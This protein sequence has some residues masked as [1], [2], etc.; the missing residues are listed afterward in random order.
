M[1]K[2]FEKVN[3]GNLASRNRSVRSS[4]FSGRA[5]EDGRFSD[6]LID[7]LEQLAKGEV[8]LIITGLSSVLPNGKA[9]PE[10]L[11]GHDDAMIPDMLRLTKR[12]HALDGKLQ[13]R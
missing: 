1:A 8:G 4:T 13:C 10:M 11:D 3:I 5:E 6:N 2:L 7:F 9:L 12:I